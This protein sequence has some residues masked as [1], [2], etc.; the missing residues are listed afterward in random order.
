MNIA[1]N[2]IPLKS[3]GGVQVGLDF[4]Y[5]VSSLGRKHRW[6]LFATEGTPFAGLQNKGWVSVK[7]IQSKLCHRLLFEYVG[8]KTYL[9]RIR[10][11]I[12][13][14]QFGPHWPRADIKNVVGCAY[15]NLF[16]PEIDFW[17]RLT[18]NERVFKKLIDFMRLRR[19]KKAD[20]IIFES[21]I[22]ARR[23]VK[24]MKFPEEKVFCVK[25]SPSSIVRPDA[26][27][28]ETHRKCSQI[29]EGFR[30][31]L[32]ANYH[33]NKNIDILPDVARV[34]KETFKDK[35]IIFVITLMPHL[36]QT[37]AIIEYSEAIGV[38]DC[39]YNIG[40]VPPQ[41]CAE[42][43]RA[44]DATILP[45]RLESF[46]NNIAEAWIMGKPLLISDL[47]WAREL[48]GNGAL[49]FKYNDINDIAKKMVCLKNSFALRDKMVANGYKVLT[50]YPTSEE[51]FLKYLKIIEYVYNC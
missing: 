30:V 37:K 2:F 46:S 40:P 20:A 11:D 33:R 39:I 6:F 42:L 44:C 24:I 8:C 51:R 27:H 5:H 10:A 36:A 31:L 48:C 15:S 47:D 38:R 18:F 50:T 21:E 41:G 26:Y 4:L 23:A 35:S 12:V 28:E 25:P 13:Y 14:T 1:L 16:Y 9:R 43:Y 29:P 17:S 3:G 22:L 32:L 49:Y 7:T 34:L 19:L 45:S